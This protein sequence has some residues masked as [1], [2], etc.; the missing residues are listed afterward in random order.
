MFVLPSVNVRFPGTNVCVA[1][2]AASFLP[3]HR[4]SLHIYETLLAE[5]CDLRIPAPYWD[6]ELDHQSLETSSI[7]SPDTGFGGD[8]A[9]TL[10]EG[11]GKGR[12]VVDGPFANT[13]RLYWEGH[14]RPHCLGRAF[15]NF[16]TK[17]SG[18]LSGAWFSPETMGEVK[19]SNTFAEFEEKLEGTVHNALHW[20][21]RGDFSS[22]SAANEPLFWLHHGQ[23][24]RLWWKW[25]SENPKGREREYQGVSFNTTE[26]RERKGT[27]SDLLEFGG[28]WGDIEVSRVMETRGELL[29]YTY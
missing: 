24:D 19:R 2:A 7:W 16:D 5:R 10:P 3:W 18:K 22:M 11:V 13:T 15:K 29:C 4:A 1:H 8:G 14:E 20:G 9:A 25:Q 26:G 27:L 12:C 28:L 21:I 23:I 17:E 6:W